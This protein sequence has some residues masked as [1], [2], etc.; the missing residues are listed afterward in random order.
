MKELLLALCLALVLEGM[1]YALFPNGM[2]RLIKT[3]LETPE[4]M[5]RL[6]GLA[7]AAIGLGLIWLIR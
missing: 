4:E 3:F 1:V 5:I 7:A 2:R 6:T